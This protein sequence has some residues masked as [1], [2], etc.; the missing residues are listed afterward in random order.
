MIRRVIE[1]DMVRYIDAKLVSNGL[2]QQVIQTKDQK[3]AR[4][5]LVLAA[6]AC[7]GIREVG[8]NNMGPMVKLIQETV[9]TA[10]GEAWCMGFVQTMIAYVELKLGV[11]SPLPATEHCMTLWD[12]TLTELRVK[13]TP[14]SG[15]VV[16]YQ[17]N[18]GSNGHCGIF[19]AREGI[20]DRNVEGNTESGLVDGAVERDGGGVYDTKRHVDMPNPVKMRKVGYL[21]P[22]PGAT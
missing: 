12:T 2:A 15:S 8:G 22:F 20:F 14:A 10:S 7:V 9:G 11:K 19:Y 5:L 18:S 4:T 6:Q 13:R 3:R 16:I 17:Y 1:N 21:I